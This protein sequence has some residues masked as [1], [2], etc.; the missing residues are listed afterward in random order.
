MTP[1]DL[2]Q[3]RRDKWHLN[4]QPVRTLE[5]ARAFIEANGFCMQY[6]QRPEI[7]APT[8][9]GAW[10]GSD[11]RLPTWQQAFADSRAHDASELM[12]R[13][14]RERDAYEAN[15]SDENN[16][17]LI[18]AS[19]F[20]YYYALAGERN[21]RQAPKPGPRAEFSQLAC[22]MFEIIKREG[23]ISK[24][25]LLQKLGGG[26]SLA[27][28]DKSTAELWSKLRITRV[29]YDPREGSSWDLLYRWA[30]D[31]VREGIGL[32]VPE[33]LSALLSKYLDCV[34]AAE[35][36]EVEAFFGHVVPR[37]RVKDAIHA[38]LAL[39]ELQFVP[40]GNRSLIQITPA[41]TPVSRDS[42]S[43][44]ATK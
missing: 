19:I 7:L 26:A 35:Q 22:D 18:A 5:D 13:L 9:V 6:P 38:L 33:A 41:K 30:P 40:V 31:P 42:T 17:L 11:D 32:S 10:V 21:P 29:D 4:A 20:P 39:G 28:V 3:L 2:E 8:F 1:Q 23:P 14:L 16:G 25:Q 44:A 27:A 15:L 12:V 36:S 43:R 37:S 24:Q 34:I